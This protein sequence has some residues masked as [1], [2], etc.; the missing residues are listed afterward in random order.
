MTC[1]LFMQTNFGSTVINL[2]SIGHPTAL[3]STI[4]QVFSSSSI[5]E[6]NI[7]YSPQ[8]AIFYNRLIY[9][10]CF[11][12]IEVSQKMTHMSLRSGFLNAN[13]SVLLK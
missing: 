6:T 7:Q 8:A 11:S 13:T 5:L 10:T 4:A 9:F 12:L 1:V 2:F 3:Q